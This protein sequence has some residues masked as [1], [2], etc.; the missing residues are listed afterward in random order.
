MLCSVAEIGSARAVEQVLGRV[1]RLPR[2]TRKRH[3]ELNCAYALAASPRFISAAQSLK[4]AL[5]E[6]GFQKMEAE[7]YVSGEDAQ[8]TFFGAGSLF[9]EAEQVVSEKPDLTHLPAELRDCATFD[10]QTST[11]AVTKALTEQDKAALAQCFATPE[12]KQAVEAV[13]QLS[14]GRPV[15]GAA[16]AGRPRPLPGAHARNPGGRS[17]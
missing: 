2:A 7:L 16:D 13:F 1:L 11:L 3:T 14:H 10:P 5:I 6:N 4:D 12:G 17:A 9:F 15:G 8:P